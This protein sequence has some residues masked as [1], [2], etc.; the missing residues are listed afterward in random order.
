MKLTNKTLTWLVAGMVSIALVASANAQNIKERTGKVVRIKGAARYSTGNKTW[1]P[2][3]VGTI[4]KAGTIVQTAANSYVDIVLNEEATA[5]LVSI[6]RPSSKA[7]AA[8]N[9][10]AGSGVANAKTTE[11]DVVR[12][13]D[14]SVLAI[15]KLSATDTGADCVTETELDLRTGSIFGSVKKQAAASRFEVK[16]PNGVAG[17]RGTIYF[18][19]VNGMVTCLTGS[20]VCAFTGDDG[21]VRTK[22]IPGGF[23]YNNRTDQ[24]GPLDERQQMS[25]EGLPDY[26][27]AQHGKS[28]G[29]NRYNNPGREVVSEHNPNSP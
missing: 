20:V 13:Q 4:L 6:P 7:A 2:L 15:D 1:Q 26:R 25:Y 16:I 10:S 24:M 29:Y 8:S 27:S 28:P 23:Q 17:I 9:T 14:D 22:V 11:H 12:L 21:K 5:D 18:I 3:K 19:H